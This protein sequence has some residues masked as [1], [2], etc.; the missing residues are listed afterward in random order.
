MIIYLPTLLTSSEVS[1]PNQ[2]VWTQF[3]WIHEL[4]LR[5]RGW[6][7]ECRSLRKCS[8]FSLWMCH[9]VAPQLSR[10]LQAQLGQAST[11][12]LV[13]VVTT[14]RIIEPPPVC[15][16]VCLAWAYVVCFYETPPHRDLFVSVRNPAQ[17]QLAQMGGG[18]TGNVSLCVYKLHSNVGCQQ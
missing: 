3:N 8:Y 14:C 18:L 4:C 6:V 15:V 10:V 7:S 11:H 1:I 12:M 16:C 13:L 17:E 5:V 2:Q 9:Q